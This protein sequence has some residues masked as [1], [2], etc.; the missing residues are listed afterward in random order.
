MKVSQKAIKKWVKAL[1][2]GKYTQ[3]QSR[4]QDANGHCCLGVACDL[5]IDQR[6]QERDAIHNFLSGDM[7]DEQPEAPKW[8]KKLSDD[9]KRRTSLTDKTGATVA[10]GF[11]LEELNDDGVH[12]LTEELGRV[13]VKPLSFDEIADLIELIYIHKAMR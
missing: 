12:Y 7:P 2:S 9:F 6:K 4:L 13:Q 8:L 11:A 5:F 3:T 1:R 10:P